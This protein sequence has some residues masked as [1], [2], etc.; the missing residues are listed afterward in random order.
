[1]SHFRLGVFKKM[2]IPMQV[3]HLDEAAD[4]AASRYRNLVNRAPLLPPVYT[5]PAQIYP[6]LANLQVESG[7]VVSLHQGKLDGYLCAWKL[8]GFRGRKAAFSPEL[9]NGAAPDGGRHILEEMYTSIAADWLSDGIAT[10]LISILA[11]EEIE[12]ETWNWLG[13]GM[14][15]VDGVRRIEPLNPAPVERSHRESGSSFEIRRAVTDDANVILA[16]DTALDRY[17]EDSP[18]FL[19]QGS[20]HAIEEVQSW[21][22]SS[23]NAFWIADQGGTPVSFLGMGPASRDACMI[24]VDSGTTSILGAF[25]VEG[26]RSQGIAAS[27]LE[28]GLSWAREH[29]YTRCAVDFEP[30]NPLGRRFWLRYFQ[31]VSFT[32]NRVVY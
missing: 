10:H 32:L 14:I 20:D 7:G 21:L 3:K 23:E 5:D 27:L 19:N 25:T 4:L 31:P 15:A 13:F 12:W 26:F 24:I 9:A 8:P 22:A 1:M 11:G 16:L 6:I 28:Q 29:G 17:L 2:I 30:Q 18:T